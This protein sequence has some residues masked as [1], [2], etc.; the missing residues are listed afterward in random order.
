MRH[1][2]AI[3]DVKKVVGKMLWR[4]G[5]LLYIQMEEHSPYQP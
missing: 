1:R 3:L 5:E 2:D 4:A